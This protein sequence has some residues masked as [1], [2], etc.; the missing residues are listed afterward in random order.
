ML[1]LKSKLYGALY[2]AAL[3]DAMGATTEFCT[4]TQI[5]EQFNNRLES[6]EQ[7]ISFI[8]HGI[9]PGSVTDDFS[10]SIYLMR[11]ILNSNGVFNEEVSEQALLDWSKDDYYFKRFSGA[12]TKKAVDMIES[13]VRPGLIESKR[14]YLGE[15][16]NGAAMKS[17]PIA[18]LGLLDSSQLLQWSLN[19]CMPTH[20][21]SSAVSGTCAV[22]YAT[23]E[24]LTENSSIDSV[25]KAGLL[26]A[27]EGNEAMQKLNRISPSADVA[28]RIERAIEDAKKISSREE[29][30]EYIYNFTGTGISVT[31]SIVAV[32]A[33]IASVSDDPMEGIFTAIN[34]GGD[35]DTIA[36]ITGA[37]L[38]ALNGFDSLNEGLLN[39]VV[40]VNE[41][42]EIKQTIERYVEMILTGGI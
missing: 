8:T 10:A 3:G 7:S 5:K 24:A 29:R 28:T 39:Q 9:I 4:Q 25:L 20:F 32:F 6:L 21:N 40:Q 33:I 35:T 1:M 38:G 16:T 34:S 36:S 41:S 19:L 37:I 26:G 31:E 30:I 11:S 14:N 18:M 17:S 12:N 23:Y 22:I 27:R 13:G 2:G 15:N 42:L